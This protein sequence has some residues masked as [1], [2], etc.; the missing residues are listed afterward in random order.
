MNQT[1]IELCDLW[2]LPTLPEKSLVTSLGRPHA[3]GFD[4]GGRERGDEL[5]A[6]N[7]PDVPEEVQP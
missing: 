6:K 4:G 5:R 2:C 7:Y 3:T 1:H